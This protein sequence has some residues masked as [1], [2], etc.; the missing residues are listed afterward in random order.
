[1]V[2]HINFN[3]LRYLAR[4]YSTAKRI[5]CVSICHTVRNSSQ[6]GVNIGVIL[7]D[8]LGY[9]ENIDLTSKAT[10]KL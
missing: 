1:M 5:H 8:K 4:M 6:N 7:V 3:L 9:G 10:A 2:S